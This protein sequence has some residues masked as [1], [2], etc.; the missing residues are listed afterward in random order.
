MFKRIKDIFKTK[1]LK[2]AGL[3]GAAAIVAGTFT[4]HERDFPPFYSRK[5]G[6]SGGIAVS[7]VVDFQDGA[8]FY[9]PVIG[10]VNLAQDNSRIYGPVIGAFNLARK[11]SQICGPVIGMLN[12]A[13]NDSQIYGPV[14]G[15]ANLAQDNSRIYGT[16]SLSLVSGRDA[17][18]DIKTKLSLIDVPI[19][20]MIN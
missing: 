7:L 14:V 11:N 8:K 13:D 6:T 15:F 18:S 5:T 4:N 12:S 10:L 1:R 19:K 2:L 16:P 3:V 9:G 20:K 17:T